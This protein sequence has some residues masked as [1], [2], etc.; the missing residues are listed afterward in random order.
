MLGRLSADGG[1]LHLRLVHDAEPRPWLRLKAL[2]TDR[3]TAFIAN[4]VA[5]LINSAQR[6]VDV[7]KLSLHD[8]QGGQVP[9][10]LEGLGSQLGRMLIDLGELSLLDA[11][12]FVRSKS[13]GKPLPLPLLGRQTLACF[14]QVHNEGNGI[15]QPDSVCSNIRGEIGMSFARDRRHR[16]GDDALGDS[17]PASPAR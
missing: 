10:P 11:V 12:G 15:A 16:A 1:A 3:L 8:L 5:A 9:F 14:G 13:L 17:G 7:L 4:P 6:L 2:F